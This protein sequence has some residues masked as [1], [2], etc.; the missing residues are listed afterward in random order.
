MPKT[1]M[2]YPRGTFPADSLDVLAEEVTTH[3]PAFEKFP[4]TTYV[5]S[6][7]WIYANEYAP[8]RVYHGGKAGGTKVISLEVNV[9]EGALDADAKKD[10]IAFLT[11]AVGNRQAFPRN[12]E[13]PFSS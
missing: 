9:I 13:C 3:A 2:E 1:F 4:D 12:S 5:R 11:D 7:I 6:N 8:E 10:F